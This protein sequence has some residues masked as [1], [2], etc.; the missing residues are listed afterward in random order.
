MKTKIDDLIKDHCSDN[1][2]AQNVVNDNP[3]NHFHLLLRKDLVDAIDKL[4]DGKKEDSG[5]YSNHLKFA[6]NKF[7]TLLTMFFNAMLRHGVA[8]DDLLLGTMFPLIK[9]SIVHIT[10]SQTLISWGFYFQCT[11]TSPS[12]KDF[13][14]V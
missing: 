7:N 2:H 9:D 8:P 6:S 10:M 3:E 12:I 5:L 4:K 1:F 11:L 13:I 14:E